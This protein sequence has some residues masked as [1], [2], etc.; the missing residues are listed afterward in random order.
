[1]KVSELGLSAGSESKLGQLAM[2]VE[3]HC[4]QRFSIRKDVMDVAALMV[5]AET[6]QHEQVMQRYLELL[7]SLQPAVRAMLLDLTGGQMPARSRAAEVAGFV[8]RVVTA[9]LYRGAQASRTAVA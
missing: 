5:V 1:M 4:K 9:G 6:C 8:G 7:D 3:V 2:A